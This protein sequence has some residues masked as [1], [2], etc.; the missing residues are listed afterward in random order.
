MHGGN[1]GVKDSTRG[2][3]LVTIRVSVR[4]VVRTMK[5]AE[6]A[7]MKAHQEQVKSER[8]RT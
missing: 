2:L 3:T 7:V 6:R 8:E 4:V 5:W 1:E